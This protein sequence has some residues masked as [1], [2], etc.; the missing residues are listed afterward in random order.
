MSALAIP[1]S[2]PASRTMGGFKPP[3]DGDEY[4][5]WEWQELKR[6]SNAAEARAMLERVAKQ[7]QPLMR[8]KRWR[9]KRLREFY[10]KNP[11]L[12]GLNVN[13]GVEI[14]VRLRLPGDPSRFF[15]YESILGTMLHE[16]VHN[17]IGPHNAA[18]YKM[19]DAI[20]EEVEGDMARGV[21]GTGAGFDARS[22]G[23]IGGRGV[24]PK[25][26]PSPGRMRESMLRAAEAR[27]KQQRVMSSGPQRLGGRRPPPGITPAQA[28]ARAAERRIAD[29]AWCPTQATQGAEVVDLTG[30]DDSDEDAV[31]ITDAAPPKASSSA[32]A[33]GDRGPGRSATRGVGGRGMPGAAPAVS[34]RAG[35]GRTRGSLG[36]R[37]WTCKFCTLLNE[38]ILTHCAACERWRF[39]HGEPLA[40]T[41]K[42]NAT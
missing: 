33:G 10:P 40:S 23:R 28:A 11:S 13:R 14:R 25:H 35:G 31:E 12:L 16:L 21:F 7:V 22:E 41:V 19:L 34:A 2:C 8:R 36:A 18:F 42:W 6:Q 29:D 24:V 3:G 38:E 9:V 1:Q 32:S 27:M 39:S 26:N 30:E 20:T 15:D 17:E 5:V 4:R 37:T